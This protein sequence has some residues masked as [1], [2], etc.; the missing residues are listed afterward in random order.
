MSTSTAS[1]KIMDNYSTQPFIQLFIRFS[2]EFGYPKF[3]LI[4]EGSQLV[5]VCQAM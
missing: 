2:C 4:N 3:M 5:K 1:V